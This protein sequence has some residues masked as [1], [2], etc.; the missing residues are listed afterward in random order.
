MKVKVIL[1]DTIKGVGK[2]DEIVEVKDGYANNF[3]FAQNK[4]VPATPENINKLKN[5]NEKIKRN[6]DNDVKK[7]SELKELLN[8]KEIVLKVKSGNNGKVFGSVGGKEIAEAIK[9]QLNIEIDKK[10]ISSDS[11]MKELGEHDVEIKLHSEVKAIIKV[12][13]E[14]QE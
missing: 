10:K 8:S 11:R 12:K 2:K 9:E 7:A 13:L 4:A 14:G 3:L 6:H 5:R 1:K